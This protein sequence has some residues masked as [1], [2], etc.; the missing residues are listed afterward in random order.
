MSCLLSLELSHC[1]SLKA[2]LPEF[3]R[4][5]P[6]ENLTIG[7]CDILE[8]HLEEQEE[9]ELGIKDKV[10]ILTSEVINTSDSVDD[11]QTSRHGQIDDFDENN[12]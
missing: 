2:P 3:L 9:G 11:P 5:T 10:K 4:R 1:F 8:R 6:L 12:K 7:R